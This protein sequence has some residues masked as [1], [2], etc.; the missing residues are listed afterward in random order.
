[1]CHLLEAARRHVAKVALEDARHGA[2]P[3]QLFGG[4]PHPIFPPRGLGAR[5]LAVPCSCPRA[6]EGTVTW[7]EPAE[8]PAGTPGPCSASGNLYKR[9]PMFPFKLTK[10]E[11]GAREAL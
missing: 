3:A 2:L 7:L 4:H 9:K 8:R 6:G 11:T 10:A 1:M 5:G